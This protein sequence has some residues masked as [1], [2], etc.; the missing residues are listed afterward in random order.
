MMNIRVLTGLVLAFSCCATSACQA[1]ILANYEFTTNPYKAATDSDPGV[2]V[3]LMSD[4]VGEFDVSTSSGVAFLRGN[5][6]EN[7]L[8]DAIATP[9]YLQFTLTPAAGQVVNLTSFIFDHEASNDTVDPFTSNLSIFASL[10]GFASTPLAAE[11]L[12]TSTTTVAANIGGGTQLQVNDVTFS[13]AASQFQ[14]LT[15]ANTV[16]FRIYGFDDALDTGQINRIDDVRVVG[17]VT[18][19]PEPSSVLLAGFGIAGCLLWQRRG[20]AARIARS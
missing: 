6:S 5:H 17:D 4:A 13:L 3:S 10:T 16:T 20:R 11:A 14:N 2:V 15:S 12:G 9:D 7:S 1:A 19:I 18:A 8:A